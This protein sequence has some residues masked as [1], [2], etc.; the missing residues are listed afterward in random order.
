MRKFALL[1][2]ALCLVV[3]MSEAT[4]AV[5]IVRIDLDWNNFNPANCSVVAIEKDI[6]LNVL[7]TTSL[8]PDIAYEVWKSTYTLNASTYLIEF[9]WVVGISQEQWVDDATG[10]AAPPILKFVSQNPQPGQVNASATA[11]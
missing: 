1:L 3:G 7:A 9:S 2:V 10:S 5:T 4:L 11:H 6:N 8:T